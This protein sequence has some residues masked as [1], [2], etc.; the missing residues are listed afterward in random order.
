[1]KIKEHKKV[2]IERMGKLYTFNYNNNVIFYSTIMKHFYS[3]HGV[4]PTFIDLPSD[5]L[6]QQLC[7]YDESEL[8]LSISEFE[9]LQ[10]LFKFNEIPNLC[11]VNIQDGY[12]YIYEVFN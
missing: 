1:M 6:F 8:G 2:R 3:K 7:S 11:Y 12:S 10:I 9:G 4:V 5:E